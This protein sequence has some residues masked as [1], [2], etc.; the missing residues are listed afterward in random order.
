MTG[1]L[2]PEQQTQ[3]NEV[4]DASS[5]L[6]LPGL[7]PAHQCLQEKEHTR[8]SPQSIQT[9]PP[10]TVTQ[11]TLC[12]AK[13]SQNKKLSLTL[14]KTFQGEVYVWEVTINMSA[15]KQQQT[16]AKKKKG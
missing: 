7:W 5:Q 4:A 10:T 13:E 11:H 2:Q 3:F 6:P 8:E 9:P 14:I 12:R 1:N 15:L 16:R